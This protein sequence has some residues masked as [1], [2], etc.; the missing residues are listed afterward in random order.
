M[1]GYSNIRCNT[2]WIHSFEIFLIMRKA[3]SSDFGIVG[4]FV[5]SNAT[6]RTLVLFIHRKHILFLFSIPQ[7]GANYKEVNKM[8]IEIIGEPKEI[9]ALVLAVQERQSQSNLAH[10]RV[11]ED[12]GEADQVMTARLSSENIR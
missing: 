2:P 6:V 4:S 7:E 1:I 8:K 10:K 9:A 5:K 11:I 12:S 3:N